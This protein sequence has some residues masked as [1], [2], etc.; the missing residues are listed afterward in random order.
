MLIC[1]FPFMFFLQSMVESWSLPFLD[2]FRS[3]EDIRL[4][5]VMC[6]LCSILREFVVILVN[7]SPCVN[8]FFLG[9]LIHDIGM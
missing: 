2:A 5:E 4:Y 7:P 9:H 3:S 8:N 1:L 6:H